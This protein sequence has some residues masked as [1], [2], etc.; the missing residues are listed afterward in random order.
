MLEVD[1]RTE[2]SLSL[3]TPRVLFERRFVPG[4]LGH[5][6]TISRDGKRF[7]LLRGDS[8]VGRSRE[9]MVVQNWFEELKRLAASKVSDAGATMKRP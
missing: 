9:L 2:R 1:V 5:T 3:S 4:D 8:S 7:L 6:W